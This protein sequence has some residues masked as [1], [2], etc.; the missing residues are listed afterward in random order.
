[1]SEKEKSMRIYREKAK[2]ELDQMIE[3]YFSNQ[4]IIEK[5]HDAIMNLIRTGEKSNYYSIVYDKPVIDLSLAET[6]IKQNNLQVPMN[7]TES[8]NY[9]KL[10][11]IALDNNLEIPTE[12]HE[13]IDW[14]KIDE[15]EHIFLTT[16]NFPLPKKIKPG[17]F[18]RAKK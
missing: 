5:Q 7:K 2:T 11:T 4:E 18:R 13:S 15:I 14:N 16:L 12:V 6:L 3:G 10:V 17:Y 8:V 1:M 9:D